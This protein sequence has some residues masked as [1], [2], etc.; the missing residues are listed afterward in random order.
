MCNHGQCISE[1]LYFLGVRPVW[2]RGSQRVVDLEVIPLS[3]LKRPWIDVTARIGGWFRDTNSYHGGMIAAVRSL[4]GEATRSYCGDGSNRQ[5]VKV[6]S[7]DEK[8]K[9]LFRGDAIE[10]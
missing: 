1:F 2:Q 4:K 6:R 8:F 5:Q 3:E 10:S 7:L 9:R